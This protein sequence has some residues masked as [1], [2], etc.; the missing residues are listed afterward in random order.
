MRQLG[1]YSVFPSLACTTPTRHMA[2]QRRAGARPGNAEITPFD[3]VNSFTVV[4]PFS[5][6]DNSSLR[7]IELRSRHSSLSSSSAAAEEGGGDL[8]AGGSGGLEEGR[9]LSGVVRIPSRISLARI[10][11][12]G[13]RL[14]APTAPSAAPR[15][16]PTDPTTRLHPSAS[17]SVLPNTFGGG[18]PVKEAGFLVRDFNRSMGRSARS[19]L[20]GGRKARVELQY[21]ST[22]AA[23][24]CMTMMSIVVLMVTVAILITSTYLFSNGSVAEKMESLRMDSVAVARLGL[25]D[26]AREVEHQL[27]E[28]ARRGRYGYTV[29]TQGGGTAG[30]AVGAQARWRCSAWRIEASRACSVRPW[31]SNNSRPPRI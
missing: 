30:A 7:S 9:S 27:G 3:G 11:E 13:A 28:L 4:S 10:A 14:D 1:S 12:T 16:I 29:H 5:G 15:S 19:G 25:E 6:L 2:A 31:V 8:E 24:R 20:T 26:A 22:T 21:T 23:I 17:S 18:A